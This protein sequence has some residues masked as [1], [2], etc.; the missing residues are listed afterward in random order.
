MVWPSHTKWYIQQGKYS[1]QKT[2]MGKYQRRS[3]LATFGNSKM[4]LNLTRNSGK[5]S[6]AIRFQFQLSKLLI[7]KLTIG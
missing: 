1:H 7:T 2:G 6:R 4:A 5:E 3:S